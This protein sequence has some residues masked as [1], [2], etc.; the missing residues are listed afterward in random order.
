M[1]NYKF[2]Q[3]RLDVSIHK[4]MSYEIHPVKWTG[5]QIGS[6]SYTVLIFFKQSTTV[7]LVAFSQVCFALFDKVSRLGC[8]PNNLYWPVA[9][10]LFEGSKV[11]V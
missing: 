2:V 5:G 1:Y 7:V 8:S 3:N 4:S 6:V 9:A 11:Q 10:R